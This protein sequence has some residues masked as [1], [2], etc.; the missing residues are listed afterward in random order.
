MNIIVAI[1]IFGLLVLVHEL[2]HFLAARK[3]GIL[4]EEFA[5]GMGPKLVGIKRGDTLYSIRLLPFGG[6]CKMLGEDEVVADDDRAFSNKSVG[7]RIVVVV[8]GAAFNIIL[9]F[10]FACIIVGNA[11][12]YTTTVKGLS[13]NSPAYNAGL[14]DGDEII[15]VDNHRIISYSEIGLYI[16]LKKGEPIDV[17]YKRNGETMIVNITPNVEIMPEQDNRKRYFIGIKDFYTMDQGNFIQVIKYGFLKVVFW[18]KTVFISL[19]MLIHGQVQKQDIGGPLRIMSEISKGYSESA[20]IGFRNVFL[21]ISSYIVL[22]S[23]N[24]GVMNLL[25]IPALDGGRLVFLLLEAIRRKPI[26]REKE[27]YVHFVGF[28]LLMILMVFL[29]YNDFRNVF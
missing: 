7:A 13:N 10:I 24:L 27:A 2:G 20:K 4:V 5:I 3:N 1:L 21:T 9:A 25:P 17:T 23:A 18:I 16:N 29:F 14:R 8:A 19:G 22:L 6:Y 15:K 26:N 12:E 28:V 11:G